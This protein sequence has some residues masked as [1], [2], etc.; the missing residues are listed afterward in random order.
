[1]SK[2][3]KQDIPTFIADLAS[4]YEAYWRNKR[5]DENLRKEV[6][7]PVSENAKYRGELQRTIDELCAFYLTASEE[8]RQTIRG[9]VQP[10]RSLH[11]G[12]FD[13]IGWTVQHKPD[14]WIMRGLAAASIEDNQE[15]FRDTYRALS[16]LYLEAVAVG[17]DASE[18]F[19]RA[20]YL[21]SA[22]AGPYL[23]QSMQDFLARFEQ[24]AYFRHSVQPKLDPSS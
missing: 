21:S 9:L 3:G 23:Q 6:I 22:I 17:L 11:N 15:D 19:Q 1:M 14:D 12:L 13:H 18:C 7:I 8:D 10:H 24:S 20:A 5:W 2:L 4:R 16:G